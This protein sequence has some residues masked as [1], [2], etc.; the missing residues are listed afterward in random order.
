MTA[1]ASEV[2]RFI[3]GKL[4]GVVSAPVYDAPGPIPA[5]QPANDFPYILLGDYFNTPNESDDALGLSGLAMIYVWSRAP[6]GKE[7]R[8]LIDEVHGALHR[9]SGVG[10]G[11]RISDCLFE[12]SRTILHDDNKTRS[13]T[14]RYRV[15]IWQA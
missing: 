11:W 4:N 8:G 5:G 12:D 14:L 10:T 7:L 2:H 3:Y 1:L 13:A 6:G 15:T 9:A